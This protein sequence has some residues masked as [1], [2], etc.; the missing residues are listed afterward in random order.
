MLLSTYLL[1]QVSTEE[2]RDSVITMK[3]QSFSFESFKLLQIIVEKTWK[4]SVLSMNVTS[5]YLRYLVVRN[6]INLFA[7]SSVSAAVSMS[8]TSCVICGRFPLLPPRLILEEVELELRPESGTGDDWYSRRKSKPP[9][10]RKGGDKAGMHH[11]ASIMDKSIP[12][13][14]FSESAAETFCLE[15]GEEPAEHNHPQMPMGVTMVLC[16]WTCRF[17]YKMK[18]IEV[19]IF[20]ST[21]E[22]QMFQGILH[23]EVW[24]LVKWILKLAMWMQSSACFSGLVWWRKSLCRVEFLEQWCCPNF[25]NVMES[26]KQTFKASVQHL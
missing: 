17:Q 5:A 8:S 12:K 1:L 24:L 15:K 23:S 25:T 2:E 20:A 22:N 19:E 3:A 16:F 14:L 10:S 6:S 13:Q 26:K 21:V 11:R 7:F 18:N 4:I 9:A